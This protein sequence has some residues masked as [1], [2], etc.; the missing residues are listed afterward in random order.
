MGRYQSAC[1]AGVHEMSKIPVQPVQTGPFYSKIG[2]N[3]TSTLSVVETTLGQNV[4]PPEAGWIGPW[5][6][7]LV[8]G[9]GSFTLAVLDDQYHSA[10]RV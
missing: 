9:S 4:I 8:S 1:E 7:P 6:G 3:Q 5:V 2:P 10:K